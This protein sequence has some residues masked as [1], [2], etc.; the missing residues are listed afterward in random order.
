[1]SQLL[2]LVAILGPTASGKSALAIEIAR[3]WEGEVVCC[4]STQLYRHFDIGTSK[5]RG[6]EQRG[7]PGNAAPS[8]STG[9]WRAWIRPRLLESRHATPQ[10]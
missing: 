8:T 5:L 4:D 9:C 6:A 2:P 3:R 1:M 7:V 10:S